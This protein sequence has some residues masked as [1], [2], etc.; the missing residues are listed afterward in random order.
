MNEFD[1][2]QEP[3]EP[4]GEEK[5][6]SAGYSTPKWYDPKQILTGFKD[7]P[8]KQQWFILLVVTG[9]IGLF[10][11]L[12]QPNLQLAVEQGQVLAGTVSYPPDNPYYMYQ[13]NAW[14]LW[15]QLAG[16]GLYLG[17]SELVVSL[18]F[19]GLAGVIFFWGAGLWGLTFSKDV[20]IAILT[21]LFLM[22]MQYTL[23]LIFGG[24]AF[25]YPIMLMGH[26][27]TYGMLGFLFVFLVY[28]LI[29]NDRYKWAFFLLGMIP[30][31]H[32]SL[33]FWAALS[34]FAAML[35]DWKKLVSN[36]KYVLIGYGLCVV[37]FLW[38]R[39]A[40]PIDRLESSVAATY[41][42]PYLAYWDGHRYGPLL[43]P[44]F[45]IIVVASV[46]LVGVMGLLLPKLNLSK[47]E[48]FL[49]R[50]VVI[51]TG[52]AVGATLV[53]QLPLPYVNEISVLLPSR[54]LNII[55][56][57][58]V[59]IFLGLMWQYRNTASIQLIL[60]FSLV[61]LSLPYIH[62]IPPFWTGIMLIIYSLVLPLVIIKQGEYPFWIM[63]LFFVAYAAFDTLIFW[64]IE[65]LNIAP[66][67]LLIFVIASGLIIFW[68]RSAA[69]EKE[70]TSVNVIVGRASEIIT[71]LSLIVI[72]GAII[73]WVVNSFEEERLPAIYPT[74][75]DP[76][77]EKVS[78]GEG[79]LLISSDD[80]RYLQLRTGRAVLMEPGA[81]DMLPYSVSSAPA[82]AHILDD[83]YGVDYFNPPVETRHKGYLA[84]LDS[85][86]ELWAERTPEEWNALAQQYG[87]T[88]VLTS[89]DWELQL[90]VVIRG[91]KMALY[92]IP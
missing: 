7:C 15:G 38:Q 43:F 29:A 16:L 41:L 83:I 49:L 57:S 87:F 48:K 50:S 27:H 36:L 82:V 78:E 31:F 46:V 74:Q 60:P 70:Q 67:S 68:R 45:G 62:V 18:I 69:A 11:G 19:S 91:D 73:V 58:Y 84:P 92:E 32:L 64:G 17:L 89:A 52:M 26:P 61:A 75:F 14:N 8:E 55:S 59:P 63:L 77:L 20:R 88:Q 72:G 22:S 44:A 47:G 35:W 21:P 71:I 10:L 24:W 79:L 23:Q 6:D 9:I 81:L 42:D 2:D 5:F 34:V 76:V 28:P 40:Y 51:I 13:V 53:S 54:F 66:L 25:N 3:V 39:L 86:Q 30:A 80:Q 12:L 65:L 1:K 85:V 90:P 33:G 4:V 37:S 56:L